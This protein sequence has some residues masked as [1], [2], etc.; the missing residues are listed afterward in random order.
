MQS[1]DLGRWDDATALDAARSVVQQLRLDLDMGELFVPGARR[2][3]GT[4]YSGIRPGQA[5]LKH[6]LSGKKQLRNFVAILEEGETR[7]RTTVET[8]Q[9]VSRRITQR[10]QRPQ[11]W[12]ESDALKQLR[13]EARTGPARS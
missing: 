5:N 7:A 1:L 11:G 12:Q 3:E 13:L 8:I 4:P 2:V 6:S 10:V 9:A